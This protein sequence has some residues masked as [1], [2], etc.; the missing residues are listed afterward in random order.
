MKLPSLITCSDMLSSFQE[1]SP[2]QLPTSL[3][4]GDKKSIMFVGN[5]LK[6]MHCFT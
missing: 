3:K 5:V 4:H 6:M 1:Y 2:E